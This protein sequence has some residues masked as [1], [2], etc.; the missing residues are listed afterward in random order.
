FR[1]VE[2]LFHESLALPGPQRADFLDT[3]CAGDADLRATV[4][5]LLR[6]ADDPT[7]CFLASPVAHTVAQLRP[8]APP[9][10]GPPPGVEPPSGAPRPRL[11]GDY[12]VLEELGRGGMGVVYK[13]R[14][15]SLGRL[16]ALKMIRDRHLADGQAVERFYRE[17]RAAAALDHP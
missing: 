5:E 13:A 15:R 3:A 17:A 9:P 6:H 11:F 10:A 14:Q 4:E 2:R 7:D 1:V 16:V 12:E 8:P